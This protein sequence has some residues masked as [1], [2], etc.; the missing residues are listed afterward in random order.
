MQKSFTNH[1]GRGGKLIYRAVVLAMMGL[2]ALE[3][4]GID[5]VPALKA[6]ATAADGVGGFGGQHDNF[7]GFVERARNVVEVGLK[8]LEDFTAQFVSGAHVGCRLDARNDSS[9][10]VEIIFHARPRIPAPRAARACIRSRENLR[11]R[12]WL[13]PRIHWREAVPIRRNRSASGSRA[14][15]GI[16]R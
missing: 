8:L 16:E 4:H 7:A 1:R 10:R 13:A 14:R 2:Y 11:W 12:T 6:V 3:G 15:A 5:F 9:R